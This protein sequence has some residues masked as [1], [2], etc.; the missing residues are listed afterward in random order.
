MTLP[1]SSRLAALPPAL[2]S[3]NGMETWD[4]DRAA[5]SLPPMFSHRLL[6]PEE[7]T[8]GHICM[9]VRC[10]SPSRGST[11]EREVQ[12]A[13]GQRCWRCRPSVTLPAL[14]SGAPPTKLQLW[15]V[16]GPNPP[17]TC[18]DPGNVPTHMQD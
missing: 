5:T 18:E 13:Q 3:G 4:V 1:V 8:H 11:A 16:E 6:L 17:I 2:T 14:P 15:K 10:C 7:S 9:C 12:S